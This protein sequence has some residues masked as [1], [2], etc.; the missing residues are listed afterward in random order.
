MEAACFNRPLSARKI[1]IFGI[2]G[3]GKSTFSLPCIQM[4]GK[5][6]GQRIS[7]VQF[8]RFRNDELKKIPLL[9]LNNSD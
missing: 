4:G 6:C 1:M 5:Q 3:S 8:M 7:M 2:P 9:L